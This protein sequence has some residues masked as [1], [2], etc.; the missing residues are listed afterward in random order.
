[1]NN[2]AGNGGMGKVPQLHEHQLLVCHCK[3]M[4]EL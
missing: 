2:F 1:M 4:L 3:Y